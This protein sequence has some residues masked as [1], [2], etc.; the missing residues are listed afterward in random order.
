LI[1]VR[2]LE[3]GNTHR[4]TQKKQKITAGEST[5]SYNF[6]HRF[7]KKGKQRNPAKKTAFQGNA[8]DPSGH[9]KAKGTGRPQTSKKKLKHQ[10]N[11]FQKGRGKRR[12]WKKARDKARGKKKGNYWGRIRNNLTRPNS[13]RVFLG[14][15]VPLASRAKKG[16]NARNR[17]GGR[18]SVG[19]APRKSEQ[20]GAE[21]CWNITRGKLATKEKET[22]RERKKGSDIAREDVFRRGTG[23]GKELGSEDPKEGFPYQK[24]AKNYKG[25]K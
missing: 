20:K 3:N 24:K 17:N 25:R 23:A 8:K 5:G 9:D 6:G 16:E 15:H 1:A 13:R 7:V 21:L 12:I 10:V 22:W 11:N 19:S 4:A 14:V 18:G 2:N